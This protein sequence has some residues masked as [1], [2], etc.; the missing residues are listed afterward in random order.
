MFMLGCDGTMATAPVLV[1]GLGATLDVAAGTA[2]CCWVAHLL[3]GVDAR[4]V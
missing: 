4:V 2:D 3:V 1:R